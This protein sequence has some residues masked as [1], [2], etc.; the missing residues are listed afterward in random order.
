[1]NSALAQPSKTEQTPHPSTKKSTST[2]PAHDQ[3]PEI[4]TG[5]TLRDLYRLRD[6]DGIDLGDV[7]GGVQTE[8]CTNDLR[9][10]EIAYKLYADRLAGAGIKSFDRLLDEPP[11]LLA[12]LVEALRQQLEVFFSDIR[13]IR[14]QQREILAAT[15]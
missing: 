8:V 2:S 9:A 7:A 5:L 15:P 10:L 1:M 13:A 3:A 4:D 11:E 6:N 14:Q 12:G